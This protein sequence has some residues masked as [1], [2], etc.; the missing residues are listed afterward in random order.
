MLIL[1]PA[2]FAGYVYS[3]ARVFMIV[4]NRIRALLF[5]DVSVNQNF[6]INVKDGQ[7]FSSPEL[8]RTF[9]KQRKYTSTFS[10]LRSSDL[11]PKYFFQRSQ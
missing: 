11:Q 4:I 6:T 8:F 1:S 2:N 5:S 10:L 7:Y 9:T 3:F